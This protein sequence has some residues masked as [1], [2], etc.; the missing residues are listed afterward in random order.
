MTRDIIGCGAFFTL[1]EQTLQFFTPEYQTRR[2]VSRKGVLI[3]GL[4][5]GSGYWTISYPID[6]LKTRLQ[7]DDI[8]SPKYK[9]FR[10]NL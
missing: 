9:K 10:I 8:V 4:L 2:D 1:Y 3:A 6:V 7:G 5:A